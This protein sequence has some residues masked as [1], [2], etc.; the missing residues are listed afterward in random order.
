MKKIIIIIMLLS[1]FNLWGESYLKAPPMDFLRAVV[2]GDIENVKKYT[3]MVENIDSYVFSLSF[4]SKY[5]G[6]PLILSIQYG[7]LEI[8]EYLLDQGAM[9][10]KNINFSLILLACMFDHYDIAELLIDRGFDIDQADDLGYTLLMTALKEKNE[11]SA[12]FLIN[13][14]ADL[15]KE[16]DTG[17]NLFH[18]IA[19]SQMYWLVDE[20]IKLDVD[21]N[22]KNDSGVTPIQVC[23][24]SNN[25]L[26]MEKMIS[27]GAVLE[28]NQL[29]LQIACMGDEV[30]IARKCL[31]ID[32]IDTTEDLMKIAAQSGS[33]K[34]AEYFV[35]SGLPL[36]NDFP[37]EASLL[38]LA[39]YGG[40]HYLINKLIESGADINSAFRDITPLLS[41]ILRNNNETTKLLIE[42][43]ADINRTDES[44]KS[45]LEEFIYSIQKPYND[46]KD[47]IDYDLIRFFIENGASINPSRESKPPRYRTPIEIALE[48]GD[49][50]LIQF[51]LD[52]GA[53]ISRQR[54]TLYVKNPVSMAVLNGNIN[55]INYLSEILNETEDIVLFS[56]ALLES[57]S[58]ND[59]EVTDLL[60]H[61]GADPDIQGLIGETP[62]HVASNLGEYKIAELLLSNGA[63]PNI[64]SFKDAAN[65][66]P[67]HVAVEEGYYKIVK[68]LLESGA[69]CNIQNMRGEVPLHISKKNN[70]MKITQLLFE[71]GADASIEDNSG[72]RPRYYKK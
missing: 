31:E 62:L 30:D 46:I 39:A 19:Y 3:P 38:Y 11:L 20:L 42:L 41:S 25:T 57:C 71:Y 13:A 58:L 47:H 10:Y 59:Y 33:E 55:M 28:Y 16:N 68:I 50:E 43:G 44:G 22:K 7:H 65:K 34:I 2:E 66:T 54:S 45:P 67:L 49:R 36:I 53:L 6:N 5:S 72:S 29:T 32:G 69:D 24:A 56:D 63:D 1:T 9:G 21:I 60:L 70:E 64:V 61:M 52:E 4:G 17:S 26:M 12:N 51:L 37:D 14:G 48:I 8:T 35:D 27:N 15:L 40:N 18:F 23:I